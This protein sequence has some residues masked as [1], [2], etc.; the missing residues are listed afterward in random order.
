M[1]KWVEVIIV[2]AVIACAVAWFGN[3]EPI[4]DPTSNITGIAQCYSGGGD[5]KIDGFHATNVMEATITSYED[6]WQR[7]DFRKTDGSWGRAMIFKG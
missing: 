4:H 2:L 1:K 6:G 3:R 5:L 7:I